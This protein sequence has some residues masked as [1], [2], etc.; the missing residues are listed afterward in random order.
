MRFPNSAFALHEESAMAF[1]SKKLLI[2]LVAASQIP[3]HDEQHTHSA[4]NTNS[5]GSLTRPLVL[6]TSTSAFSNVG[7]AAYFGYLK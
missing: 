3:L 7:L 6:G 2:P 1:D 5:A 4:F